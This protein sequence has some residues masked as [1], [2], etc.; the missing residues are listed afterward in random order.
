MITTTP[1]NRLE[2]SL[3]QSY[4]TA[5]T[6]AMQLTPKWLQLQLMAYWG[7]T[8]YLQLGIYWFNR[9]PAAD[10]KIRGSGEARTR[11]LLRVRQT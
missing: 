4:R 7:V 2:G 9:V 10:K 1:Q 3:R 5:A 11:D 8:E 6:E